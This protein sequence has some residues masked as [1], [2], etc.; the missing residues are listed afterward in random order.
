MVVVGTIVYIKSV[1]RMYSATLWKAT[2][3][4]TAYTTE[5]ARTEVVE[6]ILNINSFRGADSMENAM[7]IMV[8]IVVVYEK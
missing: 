4:L 1:M 8:G 6:I 5:K 2:G 7:I 3:L